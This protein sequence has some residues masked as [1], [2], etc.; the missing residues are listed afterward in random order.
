MR[1]P[2]FLASNK[3]TLFNLRRKILTL[4]LK[5]IAQGSILKKTKNFRNE[6][7][8]PFSDDFIDDVIFS[9]KFLCTKTS[10]RITEII[11]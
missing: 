1:D 11:W 2:Y 4:D 6:N 5:T 9:T 10:S 3:L 7:T 8:P